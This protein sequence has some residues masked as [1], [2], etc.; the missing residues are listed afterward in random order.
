MA[1]LATL[2]TE[3][4]NRVPEL[5]TTIFD[6]ADRDRAV[7]EAFAFYAA[8]RR[9]EFIEDIAGSGV[10]DLTLPGTFDHEAST[11]DSVE[12]PAGERI[13]KI[14]DARCY[15][16]YDDGGGTKVLRLLQ[17]TPQTGETVRITY[18][19]PYTLATMPTGTGG[20]YTE[21]EYVVIN[22]ASSYMCDW[23]A[24]YYS[25]TQRSS[26]AADSSDHLT[27]EQSF[28]ES[29]KRFRDLA[30]ESLGI[31]QT[32]GQE[33][34]SRG[35]SGSGGGSSRPVA[36]AS[37]TADWSRPHGMRRTRFTHV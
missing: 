15:T 3:V 7:N 34:R 13:P 26:L 27:Q 29:A 17:D 23:A 8:Y 18:D 10:F 16:L 5:P 6:S 24:A 30:F 20:A 28:H 37:A 12:Y 2:N 36:A 35:G 9:N 14:L 1:L 11:L 32:A 19:A 31:G 25:T 22:L 21:D 4:D 33:G